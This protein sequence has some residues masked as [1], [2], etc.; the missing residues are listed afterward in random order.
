MT[1]KNILQ[2]E[3]SLREQHRKVKASKAEAIKLLQQLGM[4]DKNGK[5]KKEYRISTY[6]Q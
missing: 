2:I 1:D 6:V 4:A 5:L 3:K